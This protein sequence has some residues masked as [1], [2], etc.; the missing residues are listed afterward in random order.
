MRVE[1]SFKLN[2]KDVSISEECKGDKEAFKFLYHMSEIF[3]NTV[4]ERDGETSDRV[5]VSVRKAT[6]G[7]KKEY[8]YFEMVCFDPSK[9]KCHFAK[10]QFGTPEDDAGSLFP[11]NKLDDGKWQPWTK[12][13]K[14]TGKEE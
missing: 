9:P 1:Y 3:G 4:C 12:F 6:D 7:K 10:R 2:G 11:K 13:N 8:E 5:S 14:E